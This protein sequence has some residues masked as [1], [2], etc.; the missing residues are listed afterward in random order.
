MRER[1]AAQMAV[2]FIRKA[3]APIGKLR[4]VKLMYLAERE[5]MLR[6]LLPIVEDDVCAMQR[7]M[8]LSAT[9]RLARGARSPMPTGDW[10]GHIVQTDRGLS[11]RKGVS[12]QSLDGLSDDDLHVIQQVWDDYGAMSQ[13]ELVHDVHHKLPEWDVY[14]NAKGRRSGSV[15]IPYSD[16]YQTICGV[17]EAEARFLT[18]QYRSARDRWIVSDPEILGGT[19][20]V[21]GT[22]VSVYAIRGR[23]AGGDGLAELLE[24]YPRI[25]LEAL[26][27]ANTYA[28]TKPLEP[29]PCGKPWGTPTKPFRRFQA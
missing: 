16:L 10:G 12:V 14:W 29:H 15:T 28:Q 8:A 3:N 13:D 26:H 20:V 27:A 18:E 22:R 2:A 23:L 24:D 25:S 4:L 21:V 7:G 1:Q 19:P 6:Y 17:D 5:A 11:V 9:W